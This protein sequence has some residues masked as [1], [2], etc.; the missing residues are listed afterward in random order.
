MPKVATKFTADVAVRVGRQSL[1]IKLPLDLADLDGE[2]LEDGVL[3]TARAKIN[4]D[5]KLSV[6][7]LS[8]LKKAYKAYKAARG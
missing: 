5:L 3:G 2:K 7:N 6:V 4:E 1:T 8:D